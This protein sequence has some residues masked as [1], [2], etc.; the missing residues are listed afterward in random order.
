M[1]IAAPTSAKWKQALAVDPS[2]YGNISSNTVALE[3]HF[4]SI[5]TE[6]PSCQPVRWRRASVC[7]HTECW[8]GR[9]GVGGRPPCD[10]G[11]TYRGERERAVRRRAAMLVFGIHDAPAHPEPPR[12]GRRSGRPRSGLSI[13]VLSGE[14][15]KCGTDKVATRL[16]NTLLERQPRLR[17]PR[18]AD[19]NGLPHARCPSTL[20]LLLF[21][22]VRCCFWWRRR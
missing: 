7:V 14:L 10:N 5:T 3:D 17:C 1:Y 13:R 16:T 15:R 2:P 12:R 11:P 9:G 6:V 20:E 19:S 18:R 4:T 8:K 22:A 21:P